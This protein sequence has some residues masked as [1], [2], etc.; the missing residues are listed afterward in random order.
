[1]ARTRPTTESGNVFR[2]HLT[3][4]E[5]KQLIKA[6]KYRSR[7]PERDSTLVLMMYRHGLR[8]SEAARLRWSDIDLQGASIYIRRQK[9]SRS[10]RHPL[11]GDEIRALRRIKSESPYVFISERGCPL[12]PRTISHIINRAGR[13]AEFEFEVNSHMMRHS[14][15]YYLANKGYDTRLIQDY[16]GHSN[17]QNTVRYTQLN[18]SRFEGIWD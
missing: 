5:I 9:G 17:I 6:V 14:C 4:A 11:Q 10:G 16:L 3:P 18:A 2:D 7:N 12:S 13:A 8:R 15:G 1:M